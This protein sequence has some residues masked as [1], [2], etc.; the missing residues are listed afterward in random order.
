MLTYLIQMI[1]CSGILYAYYHFFL[2]NE[3]FHQ[4]NRFYLL[5]AIVLSLLLPLLK[6][7]VEVHE[8]DKN[9][10]YAFVSTG[11]NVA[12]SVR[13]G[14]NYSLLP[15]IAYA[16]IVLLLLLKLVIAIIKIIRIKNEAIPEQLD[17]ITLLRTTHPESPF[18]FFN[19]LFWNK[20]TRLDA[21]EGNHIFRHEMYHIRS[22]HSRD[23]IFM[24]IILCIAWFN[25]FF[26]GFRKEIK[27]IQEF[28]ADKHATSNGD[29]SDYASLLLLQAINS[30]KH[31]LVNP[32]FQNQL[33]RRIAMLLSSKEPRLQWLRKLLVLPI[34]AITLALFGFTYKK[35]I[36]EAVAAIPDIAG[37]AVS[38]TVNKNSA[39][40]NIQAIKTVK[41]TVP[42]SIKNKKV[43]A[44]YETD[45]QRY[46]KL[47]PVTVVA[48]ADKEPE[49]KL[50]REGE[51]KV[52]VVAAYPGSWSTFLERNLDAS[53]AAKNGAPA[54][55]YQVLVRF[56]I[57]TDGTVS[58]CVPLTDEGYGMED[59][60]LRVLKKSGRWSPALNNKDGGEPKPVKSYRI[61]P[62]NFQVLSKKSA[63]DAVAT[64]EPLIQEEV[65]TKAEQDAAYPGNWR[66]FLEKNLNGAVPVDNKA[67]AG[68]YT[69]I[70]QFIVDKEG[71]T[72]H[73]KALSNVG[74]GMEDEALR[75][76][77]ASGKW[78]PAVQNGR[79]VAAYRKQPVTFQILEQ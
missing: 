38:N 9:P 52:D 43:N 76:I 29:V 70:I 33:K 68:N 18:S 46:L 41:D 54:G 39:S 16:I 64:K 69:T 57:N 71:N 60:V 8:A 74:Y 30:Q 59:E 61:Q 48:W 7:P 27:T 34:A 79:A 72:S 2:R 44:L 28:L 51:E 21:P 19:W 12:V 50:L 25:P 47:N 5:S 11:E 35:E 77:K 17:D 65:F 36:K 63:S 53:I 3:K 22:R 49:K 56:I 62:V 37:N 55:N 6:I 73:F 40:K 13:Q 24:E 20:N 78:E 58:D 26:Y 23:I 66:A 10:I 32:F 15:V 75:A 45:Q 4:Y 42:S 1:A 14:L 31:Q 67:P